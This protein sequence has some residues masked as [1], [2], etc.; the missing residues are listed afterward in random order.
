MKKT[1]LALAVLASLAFS[2]SASACYG[3]NCSTSTT[4]N[5]SAGISG[6]ARNEVYA[7]ASVGAAPGTSS[8]TATGYSGAGGVTGGTQAGGNSSLPLVGNVV[9]AGAVIAAGQFSAVGGDARNISTGSGTGG[10]FSGG[11][12]TALANASADG[13]VTRNAP[14]NSSDGYAEFKI[15]GESAS[16][17]GFGINVGRNSSA[18]ASARSAGGFIGAGGVAINNCSTNVNFV[19]G[20]VGD[21]SGNISYASMN[22]AG[23][24]VNP[25]N[26]AGTEVDTVFDGSYK[27]KSG[28]VTVS[29][30]QS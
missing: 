29:G 11:Y 8:S 22:S 27:G 28:A 23:A 26:A 24:N 12:A 4:G 9:G 3:N 16:E 5:Q 17:S 21:K 30:N 14:G 7:T 18:D 6:S 20:G 10:A 25:T 19:G 13:S 2:G 1:L 15:K